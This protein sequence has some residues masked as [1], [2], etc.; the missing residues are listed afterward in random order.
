MLQLGDTARQERKIRGLVVDEVDKS[1]FTVICL[2]SQRKYR[3]IATPD[4]VN[5]QLGSYR[6][7]G[8]L[9]GRRVVCTIVADQRVPP[10]TPSS[11]QQNGISEVWS[12]VSLNSFVSGYSITSRTHL[13][14]VVSGVEADHA[15]VFSAM[16]D[17]EAVIAPG[18]FEG[19][20][21]QADWIGWTLSF[22]LQPNSMFVAECH[23]YDDAPDAVRR[24]ALRYDLGL[25]APLTQVK[26]EHLIQTG[27]NLDAVASGRVASD[28][29]TL[30]TWTV[31]GCLP[32]VFF[33]PELNIRTIDGV[34][35]LTNNTP[36][37]VNQGSTTEI[38]FWAFWS[39][40]GASLSL[41]VM[42]EDGE[43]V[44]RLVCTT[45]QTTPAQEMILLDEL[46]PQVV[47]QFS[48]HWGEFDMESTCCELTIQVTISRGDSVETQLTSKP[49]FV[50]SAKT[51]ARSSLTDESAPAHKFWSSDCLGPGDR[52]S[53]GFTDPG[54][55][56]GLMSA[57]QY[58]ELPPSEREVIV[59]EQGD[60]RLQ[61]MLELAKES[62]SRVQDTQHRA[63][64]LLWFVSSVLGGDSVTELS[65]EAGEPVLP[66]RVASS[67][68]ARRGLDTRKRRRTEPETSSNI[69]RLGQ[70]RHGVCRHRS[71]LFKFLC[72]A[73]S[74]P[75]FLLRGT[76]M[77]QVTREEERHTWN[78][79]VVDVDK[80]LLIDC[81]LSP[82][83][84]L[85]WPSPEYKC[86]TPL[87]LSS[88]DYSSLVLVRQAASRY[89]ALEEV[90][91]G[92]CAIVRRL[93][94]GGFAVVVKVP[95]SET[96]VD[97]LLKEYR[98]LR[99]FQHSQFV[100]QAFGWKRGII[101]EYFPMSLLGF[102]NQMI[103]RKQSMSFEQQRSVLRCVTAA[104]QDVHDGGVLHR[105]VK[106]EN[107]LV[108]VIRCRSCSQLGIMCPAC[109]LRAK[110]A[111]FADCVC[112]G[113][114]KVKHDGVLV[115]TVPYA[116]PEIEALAPYSTP[117]D[118]WSV[119]IL[120][121]EMANMQLP[122]PNRCEFTTYPCPY[123]GG[124]HTV[125]VPQLSRESKPPQWLVEFLS[126]SLVVDWK[127]RATAGELN[128]ILTSS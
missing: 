67:T 109:D 51:A 75:C 72:D 79:V 108:M 93:L 74:V 9:V 120:A 128:K 100:V 32:S 35:E 24:G 36:P 126:K 119:G 45:H 1:T 68:T 85:P 61:Q 8:T 52:I 15:F 92:A 41:A 104:I 125:R 116:A 113:T 19:L 89:H 99:R 78:V 107:V 28:S 80:L 81:M 31:A 90:G 30:G 7:K 95:R 42:D 96:D 25:A 46:V 5:A 33:H 88:I 110:L 39:L 123:L 37:M 115:G 98:Y 56:N 101:L 83:S 86:Q 103:L 127:L 43:D 117:A 94:I 14:G 76:H 60:K 82:R 12:T 26:S 66:H 47:N 38:Q 114:S 77:D 17:E 20:V 124:K 84:P 21:P 49:I 55:A 27:G 122:L 58:D 69:V 87:S 4:E 22:T 97:G 102:I 34:V 105:D 63:V 16:L 11:P 44:T 121:V 111:D 118:V 23:R 53:E 65:T 54:R 59:V 73:T 64:S 71:L 106:A 50:R 48:I 91:R 2:Q 70:V 57:K 18:V 40:T 6:R 112:L 29:T 10:Q 3:M 62:L 13:C